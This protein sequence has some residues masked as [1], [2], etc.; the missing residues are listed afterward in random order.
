[1]RLAIIGTGIA[2]N[3]AAYCLS[4]NSANSITVYEK[5]TWIG[6]HSATVDIDHGGTK[7]AVDTGFIVYNELNYPELTGLFGH[8]GVKTEVS[9]MSFGVSANQ[10]GYEWCGRTH[11]VL[12][13]LFA[14]KRN[15]L[16]PRHIG[17]LLEILRFNTVARADY[18]SGRLIGLTLGDYLTQK[19]FSAKFRDAYLVPMG[20]SIWSM[21]P[22]AMLGFPIYSFVDFCEKHCLLQWDRPVWLTVT[23]GSR[24][25]VKALTAGF[26]SRIKLSTAATKIQRFGSEVHVWDDKGMMESFDHVIM[27]CHSD[28]SLA[29][30]DNPCNLER[31]ILGAIRYKDNDV[32]LHCDT[33]LMPKRK[34]AWAAWN[35]L[36]D[37]DPD[38]AVCLTYWMNILQNIDQ[39]KP[40]F[41]TLNPAGKGY[42]G[43]SK[44]PDNLK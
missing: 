8:L 35:V 24:N 25:Y 13:G 40:V 31:S 1:M 41:V 3:T 15:L 33:Q 10:G 22:K 6:G 16:S 7:I 39:A 27:A 36:Q 12:R 30:I 43:R 34:Q 28:Q 18:Q 42:G 37:P 14:Q 9:D 20:A 29:L 44:L 26:Q 4:Q 38:Q 23:G 17:M 2:G 21:S 11:N 5:E 32:W 19:K